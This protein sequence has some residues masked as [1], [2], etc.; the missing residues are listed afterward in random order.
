[1]K[2]RLITIS[3]TLNHVINQFQINQRLLGMKMRIEK[4][5]ILNLRAIKEYS[6][7]SNV[8]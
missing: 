5:T 4:K 2:W 7:K 3:F 1:M 8:K 6:T